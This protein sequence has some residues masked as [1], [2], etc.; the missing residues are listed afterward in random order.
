MAEGRQKMTAKLDG[1]A[2]SFLEKNH[3]AAMTTLRADGS[4]HTVRVGAALV[5]GKV[6]SSGTQDRLRTRHLRR[7][8]R[9]A[10]MVFGEG[11]GYLG[12]ECRVR[13]LEGPDVPELSWRLFEVMQRGMTPAPSPGKLVWYG[14]EKTH[15]EF[16]QAMIAERRLIYEFDVIRAY[17]LYQEMPS[18]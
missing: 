17:G 8:S 6:W 4:P 2:F 15:E 12:L 9:A 5:D 11:F 10:L 14:Q 3:Q 7:D 1:A 16:V 13:T 18:R